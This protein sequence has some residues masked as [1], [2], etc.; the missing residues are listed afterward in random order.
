MTEE[1]GYFQTGTYGPASDS[2]LQAVR[3]TMEKE[4]RH[5][6]ATPAGRQ[7]HVE[8][9]ASARRGLARMLNVREEELSI[10]TNTSRAMQQIVRGLNW[11]PGD[12]FIMT[13]L[14]HVSTYG[15]S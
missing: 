3:E 9:E 11:Q 15:L 6:P 4:A 12:E 5:G 13:S 8:R 1:V 10:D 14:E 7:A 2:V